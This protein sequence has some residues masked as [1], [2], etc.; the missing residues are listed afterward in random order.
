M[1]FFKKKYTDIPD[2]ELMRLI[3]HK[4]RLAFDE[5]YSRYSKPLLNYFYKLLNFDK[6]YAEDLL[7]DLFLKII[8]K[9]QMFDNT[10]KFSAWVYTVASNM[11]KNEYRNKQTHSEHHKLF[12]VSRDTTVF[13]EQK[14]DENSFFKQLN[15]ELNKVDEELHTMFNLRYLDQLPYKEIAEIFHC[16]EGT[17]KSR[18]FYLTKNLSIKLSV[19]N[20][21]K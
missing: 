10:R 5:I 11:V 7:H 19:L 12:A 20:P 21:H 8:E 15:E 4:D 16:P 9:P 17:V 1:A 14:V 13:N 2:E 3:S 6:E 18:L